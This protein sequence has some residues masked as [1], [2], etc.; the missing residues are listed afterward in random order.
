MARRDFPLGECQTLPCAANPLTLA[1]SIKLGV[2]S[3]PATNRTQ[4]R[5][6]V[7]LLLT[8]AMPPSL[9]DD[10]PT[11]LHPHSLDPLH[12][13]VG[14]LSATA[15]SEPWRHWS[16]DAPPGILDLEASG[17]GRDSYPIEIGYVLS[18]G[19]TFCSLIRP[20]EGWTHWDPSAEQVHRIS[21]ATTLRHGRT[22][23][24]IARDLN[25]RLAG[26][27]LYCDA[28]AHDYTWLN[29]LYE[30][31]DMSPSFKLG[32]LRVLLTEKEAA[33]WD[34]LKLEVEHELKLERHRA[35]SDARLLQVTLI[36]LRSDDVGGTSPSTPPS[37]A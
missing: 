36:R 1:A 11:A 8:L 12:P 37:H 2:D 21:R 13:D 15:L 30:E 34:G 10:S 33:R 29:V 18:N 27:T 24:D 3:F 28:W 26:Q 6:S 16:S 17:F 7:R 25:Q 35:S 4:P 19:E 5:S 31:A 22:A 23:A 20:A 14:P 32:H 9:P